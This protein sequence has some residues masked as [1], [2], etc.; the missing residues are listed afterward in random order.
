[1]GVLTVLLTLLGGSEKAQEVSLMY[2]SI[3]LLAQEARAAFPQLGSAGLTMQATWWG[4]E[5]RPFRLTANNVALLRN[6]TAVS[7]SRNNGI[8]PTYAATENAGHGHCTDDDAACSDA[9]AIASKHGVGASAAFNNYVVLSERP[10]IFYFPEFLTDEECDTMV[11]LGEDHIKPSQVTADGG[12][13]DTRVRSSKV[14][15]LLNHEEMHAVP[16]A[17]KR[18]THAATKLPYDHMEALQ[19][20]RYGSPRG[21]SKDFYNPHLDSMYGNDR[22]VATMIYYLNDCEEGGETLFPYVN[23][24]SSGRPHFEYDAQQAITEAQAIYDNACDRDDTG[25]LKVKPKK[26]SAVLFYSLLPSGQ[27]DHLSVHSS[28]PVKGSSVKWISQ[29]WIK[30]SWHEPRISPT[31]EGYWELDELVK[32]V[33]GEG[34]NSGMLVARDL[35][36]PSLPLEGI[37]AFAEAR[38]AS[39]GATDLKLAAKGSKRSKPKKI[40]KLGDAMRLCTGKE[41]TLL[42]A[43]ATSRALTWVVWVKV[44]GD[45]GKES[46]ITLKTAGSANPLEFSLTVNPG[47]LATMRGPA[48]Q[49]IGLEVELLPHAWTVLK[50]VWEPKD[51]FHEYER[52]DRWNYDS[53]L[54]A[55]PD[56]MGGR[57]SGVENSADSTTGSVHT[58]GV[59]WEKTQLCVEKHAG[60]NFAEMFLFSHVLTEGEMRHVDIVAGS[61]K[62][63]RDGLKGIAHLR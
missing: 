45:E 28:C 23:A 3:D 6:G 21:D 55:G 18:K 62:G 54:L 14:H 19:I 15:F 9:A 57:G 34:G 46:K 60:T 52:K 26:G 63:E 61:E 44:S 40:I 56:I 43:L 35:G 59:E 13:I 17:V 53:Y 31:C 41:T 48:D 16:Q 30:E 27:L 49:E 11:A 7:V 47:G 37:F 22:R 38:A 8:D 25:V 33:G 50:M 2:P 24:N 32:S 5:K 20:Q 4:A 10:R 42:K 36:T 29:Q 39:A 1:M 12:K 58:K 51:P